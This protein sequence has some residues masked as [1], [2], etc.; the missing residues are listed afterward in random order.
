MIGAGHGGITA[1]FIIPIMGL[2]E[3]ARPSRMVP[4]IWIQ[5]LFKNFRM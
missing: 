5:A 4:T 3:R 2:P 1:T